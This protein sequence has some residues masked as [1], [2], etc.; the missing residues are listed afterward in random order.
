VAAA[1]G[2]LVGSVLPTFELS[3]TTLGLQVLAAAAVGLI[4]AAWPAW[5][6]GRIDI[7]NGLR[8]VA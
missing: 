3:S 5:Q 1:F 2:S 4:A 8:H 7:V 6:M